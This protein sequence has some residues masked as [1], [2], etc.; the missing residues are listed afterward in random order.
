MEDQDALHDAAMS[1]RFNIETTGDTVEALAV[2]Q[3]LIFE[4]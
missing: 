2:H 3:G 1:K 4:N